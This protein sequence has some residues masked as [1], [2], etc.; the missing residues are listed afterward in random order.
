MSLSPDI[1]RHL[2]PVAHVSAHSG[3]I[4]C[5]FFYKS[6]RWPDIHGPNVPLVQCDSTGGELCSFG[7][8]VW[9]GGALSD[10]SVVRLHCVEAE[11][12]DSCPILT[13]PLTS[14][15]STWPPWASGDDGESCPACVLRCL[16]ESTEVMMERKTLVNWFTHWVVVV[17]LKH[18][19]E[20][21]NFLFF[22]FHELDFVVIP[23]VQGVWR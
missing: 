8:G 13:L 10:L 11:A 19:Q 15:S 5:F 16:W 12:Q 23:G 6:T 22:L 1:R 21:C 3:L 20:A 7:D 17:K 4:C 14:S 9:G 2:L 18:F